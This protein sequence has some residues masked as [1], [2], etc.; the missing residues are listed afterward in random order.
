MER[1]EAFASAEELRSVSSRAEPAEETPARR[2]LKKLDAACR[3]AASKGHDAII[4][5]YPDFLGSTDAIVRDL[6]KRGFAVMT[7]EVFRGTLRLRL[8][9]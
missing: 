3:L 6:A 9:W 2:V 8:N 7:A 1:G 4:F 5:H